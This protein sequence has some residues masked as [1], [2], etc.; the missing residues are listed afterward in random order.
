M[1]KID[2]TLYNGSLDSLPQAIILQ[3]DVLKGK[4]AMQ[5]FGVAAKDGAVFITTKK[6]LIPPKNILIPR[7]HEKMIVDG[8]NYNGQSEGIDVDDIFIADSSRT[9][10]TGL[11]GSHVGDQLIIITKKAAKK[12][13][14]EKLS[15]F[16]KAYQAYL[17]SHKSDDANVAYVINGIMVEDKLKLTSLYNIPDDKIK[18]V[19]MIDKPNEFLHAVV[20]IRIK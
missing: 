4:D 3:I 1:I 10:T 16:C 2:D 14:Q 15:K 20:A 8:K 6:S 12:A 17:Q 5:I 18:S 9:D 19:N 7:Y 13:Y 11:F